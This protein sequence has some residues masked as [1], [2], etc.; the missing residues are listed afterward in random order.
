[1][2]NCNGKS[3]SNA[4]LRLQKHLEHTLDNQNFP[5]WNLNF[6]RTKAMICEKKLH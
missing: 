1:M 5:K 3:Y 4:K 6:T 2:F